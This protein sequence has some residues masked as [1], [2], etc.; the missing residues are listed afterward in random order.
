MKMNADLLDL[1]GHIAPFLTQ[2]FCHLWKCYLWMAV[3]NLF[4]SVHCIQNIPDEFTCT[5]THHNFNNTSS[6]TESFVFCIYL[7]WT[8]K[9]PSLYFM[10]MSCDFFFCFCLL[11]FPVY[12]YYYF[13]CVTIFIS[14]FLTFSMFVFLTFSV[15]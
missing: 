9:V 10:W 12:Y 14:V 7:L 5:L 6:L 4:P 8:R 1:R 13:S 3:L 2:D 11:T 15:F